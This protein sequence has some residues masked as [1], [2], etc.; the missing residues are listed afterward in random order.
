MR[1]ILVIDDHPLVGD[2]ISMMVKDMED[3]SLAAVCKSGKEALAYLETHS[4]DFILLDINLPD[5]DGLELCVQI[6]KNHKQVKIIGLTSTNEAGIITQLLS[7]G[8][9]GYL[10]KNMEREEL[11]QALNEVKQGKIFLSKAANQ[12]ILE[13]FQSVRE[14]MQKFPMLTRREKEILVLL[15]EGHS[16]P[17]IADKLCLS[18]FT[19]ETH[20]KNLMQKLEVNTTQQLLKVAREYKLV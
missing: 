14:A 8:A 9:N 12:K 2:G 13:Q 11:I 1:S 3:V 5:I 20:R 15:Y 7:N 17:A 6:R 4:P 18:P 19:I 16:G 10:L